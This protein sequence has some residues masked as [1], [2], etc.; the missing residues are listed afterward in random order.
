MEFEQEKI[1]IWDTEYTSWEGCLENGWDEEKDQ[2]KEIIQIGAV[3]FD[4]NKE[5]VVDDFNRFVRPKK[6]PELSDYIKNL[7]GI[8][9]QHMEEADSFGEVLKDFHEWCQNYNLYSYGNDLEVLKE[10]IELNGLGKKVP[11]KR[12]KDI[13]PV[14]EDAGVPTERWASGNI[15]KYFRPEV[16]LL[17]QHNAL[18]DSKNTAKALKLMDKN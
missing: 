18:N 7:T 9:Q 6:N 1:V 12:F 15:A 11:G 3:I 13:R 2:Y 10:N 4:I 8:T 17:P 14:F 5:E 16:Q